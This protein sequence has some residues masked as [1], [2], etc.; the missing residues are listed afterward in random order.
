MKNVLVLE[1]SSRSGGNTERLTNE[2]LRDVERTT[3]YLREKTILPIVDKRHD[4]E[5]FSIVNDDHDAIMEEVF[6]H[7]ILIFSTPIYW[8]SMSGLMKT[9]IDRWSQTLRDPRFQM[10]AE[11]KKKEAFVV[12][13]GGD[14]PRMK[15]LPLIQQFQY[16]FDFIGLPFSDYVIGQGSKPG[17][18][19]NDPYALHV[20]KAL[21]EMIKRKIHLNG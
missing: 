5:G 8:Y 15:G 11:M 20:A 1:G 10:K 18:I 6:K 19:M 4:E 7:D 12:A 17:E 16:A 2:V 13:C 21:N 9:F 3:I 14:N